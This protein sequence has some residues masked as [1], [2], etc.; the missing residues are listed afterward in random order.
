MSDPSWTIAPKALANVDASVAVLAE[1]AAEGGRIATE[2]PFD[3]AHRAKSLRAALLAGNIE[4]WVAYAGTTVVADLTIFNPAEPE[5]L[6]GM[7]VA[8]AHRR[9]GIG[10]AL[11]EAAVAWARTQGKSALRLRVFPDNEPARA[12]Y[13]ATQF[14]EVALQPGAVARSDGSTADAI[15]MRRALT[16]R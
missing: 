3:V 11:I 10:R 1:A 7:V 9:H 12:L 13:R 15:L 4:G 8:R 2:W 5:P 14:V 6:F 16:D